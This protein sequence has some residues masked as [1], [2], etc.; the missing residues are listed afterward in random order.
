MENIDSPTPE[1]QAAIE[2]CPPNVREYIAALQN[3]ITALQAEVR[4]LATKNAELEVND[5]S[6]RAKHKE[7]Q[8]QLERQASEL[9]RKV[10]I[11]TLSL[12]AMQCL[13][14]Y[15]KAHPNE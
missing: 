15:Y 2:N 3:Q 13:R 5:L 14:D 11:D 9:E 6:M 4:R 8:K 12:G 10:H 1:L 7:F